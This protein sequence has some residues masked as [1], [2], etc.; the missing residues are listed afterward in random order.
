MEQ[1]GSAGAAKQ[2]VELGHF[3]FD[4]LAVLF[5]PSDL[6]LV[7]VDQA[8]PGAAVVVPGV[9][10]AAFFQMAGGESLL[11]DSVQITEARGFLRETCS[12]FS[13]AA[14]HKTFSALNNL[15]IES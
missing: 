15:L 7:E 8:G 6:H 12:G 1:V 11:Y 9:V 3:L 10:R 4:R 14:S 2:L 5:P 13:W